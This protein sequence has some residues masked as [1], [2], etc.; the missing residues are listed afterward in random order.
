VKPPQADLP[1][2]LRLPEGP[3]CRYDPI[4]AL[5]LVVP[6]LEETTK[7]LMAL[8]AVGGVEGVG[9]LYALSD[10]RC[11]LRPPNRGREGVHTVPMFRKKPVVIEAR[12]FFGDEPFAAIVELANWCKASVTYPI[13]SERAAW[14][15]IPTP[16]GDHRAVPGDWIVKGVKGEFYPCKPDI[17]AMTYEA[18]D[19]VEPVAD[20]FVAVSCLV[21]GRGIGYVA[22]GGHERWACPECADIDPAEIAR[23]LG[24]GGA[25]FILREPPYRRP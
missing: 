15:T 8:G 4:A 12:Q 5:R 1:D 20:G 21:C 22:A 9:R 2:D 18:A 10:A 23:P 14:L 3:R 17:F 13:D 25:P 7:D 6:V 19:P 11:L 24:A 16:E